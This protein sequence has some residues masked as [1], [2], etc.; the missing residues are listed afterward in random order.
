MGPSLHTVKNIV[1]RKD[2]GDAQGSDSLLMKKM[3]LRYQDV[4]STTNF[5]ETEDIKAKRWRYLQERRSDRH[6]DAVFVYLD[7]P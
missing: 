7:K 6:K 5:V 3:G 2:N 4:R 1:L